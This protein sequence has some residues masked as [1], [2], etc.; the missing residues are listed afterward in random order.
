MVSFQ[1]PVRTGQAGERKEG[2]RISVAQQ[3]VVFAGSRYGKVPRKVCSELIEGFDRLGFSFLVGCA[4]GVDRSFREAL[5]GSEYRDK[6]M[7]ACA[8]GRRERKV[9]K[10]GLFAQVV[11]SSG[12]TP[13][14]AL[15]RRTLWMVCRCGLIVLVPENPFDHSWG[16]GSQLVF[17]SAMY[18]M[19]PVFVVSLRP[20]KPSVHYRLLSA[21]LFEL[22][23]GYWVVPSDGRYGDEL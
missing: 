11:V 18:Q 9:R 14:A 1:I 19:K 10:Q 4:E 2:F 20:H 5:T 23:E 13:K 22:V 3:P 15:H 12:L 6:S 16:K 7:V 8:F 21:R 17:R